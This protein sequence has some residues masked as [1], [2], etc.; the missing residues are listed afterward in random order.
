[1]VKL[2]LEEVEMRYE[3]GIA[4]LIMATL[5]CFRVVGGAGDIIVLCKF[6]IVLV[7]TTI[8]LMVARYVTG[9]SR[10]KFFSA[11]NLWVS[12]CFSF[13]GV[14]LAFLIFFFIMKFLY[15]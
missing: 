12:F 5:Y 4:A 11:E 8:I 15:I 1:M 3:L 9:F 14:P 13:F 6:L 2:R 10:K 7:L